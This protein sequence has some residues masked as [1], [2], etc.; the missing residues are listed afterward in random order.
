MKIK[1]II[2]LA[3]ISL[4][5]SGCFLLKDIPKNIDQ[6]IECDYDSYT[7]QLEK[8]YPKLIQNRIRLNNQINQMGKRSTQNI[9]TVPVVVHVIGFGA[10]AKVDNSQVVQQIQILNNDFRR[11]AGT[12]GYGDGV[13][14]KIEFCFIR[15]NLNGDSFNGINRLDQSISLITNNIQ[16][17]ENLKSIIEYPPDNFLN[18]YVVECGAN[19]QGY[20]I[21]GIASNPFHQYSGFDGVIIDPDAFG[22][23]PLNLFYGNGRTLTH[24]V[25][26]WLGLEHIF[27]HDPNNPCINNDP[28][29]QGDF[30]AD[31][32]PQQTKTTGCPNPSKN[33]CSDPNDPLDGSNDLIENYMDYTYQPCRNMFTEGQKNRMQN[34]LQ[35]IRDELDDSYCDPVLIEEE[36]EPEFEGGLAPIKSYSITAFMMKKEKDTNLFT[37]RDDIF[38]IASN[39]RNPQLGGDCA[40]GN[41]MEITSNISLGKEEDTYKWINFDPPIQINSMYLATSRTIKIIFYEEDEG[42]N[43]QYQHICDNYTMDFNSRNSPYGLKLINVGDYT[44]DGEIQTFD[45]GDAKVKIKG[46]EWGPC[47]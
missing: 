45:I 12:S 42:N 5:I 25:G 21:N 31:T 10:L 32:P 3:T 4:F 46:C 22:E 39:Y 2:A 36:E 34:V 17:K 11:I 26:H 35:V 13:D 9:Y 40:G 19:S 8:R 30:V 27:K 7:S 47:N 33:S 6:I 43:M 20:Q 38:F 24:E 16:S 18:I 41:N 37:G 23:N 28:I 14:T 29:N 44:Y 15:Q 1:T